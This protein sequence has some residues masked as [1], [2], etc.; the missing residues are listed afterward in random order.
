MAGRGVHSDKETGILSH[1]GCPPTP[2]PQRGRC[3][4]M[5]PCFPGILVV[6]LAATPA[7]AQDLSLSACDSAS[8][9][10]AG[11]GASVSI[12][13]GDKKQGDSSFQITLAQTPANAPYVRI[14]AAAAW[15]S[16]SGI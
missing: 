5:K 8:P 11:G 15:S 1:E 16:Y 13:T 3:D 9:Y 7:W 4:M 12:N 14:G 6:L 2:L 10:S